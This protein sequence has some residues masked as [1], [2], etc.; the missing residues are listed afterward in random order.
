M[1][2]AN[3]QLVLET[4]G[5]AAFCA[6]REGARVLLV[7]ATGCLGGMGTSGLV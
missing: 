7:E 4:A 1:R 2:P 6:A 3:G 5:S